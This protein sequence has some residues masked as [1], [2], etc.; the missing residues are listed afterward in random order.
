MADVRMRGFERRTSVADA[1]AL[2]RARV[3]ELP[4]ETAAVVAAAERVLAAE[5][6]SPV[7][8]PPFRRAMMDGWAVVAE[9]T[10]GASDYRPALLC[11][12]GEV[13]AGRG[14]FERPIASGEAL[15]ITTGAPLPDGA[16]AVVMAE[17]AVV[18]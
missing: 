16:D 8:L 2:L 17:I 13:R 9:S 7:D 5:V 1:L 12:V 18:R 10:L 3:A 11:A 4:A 14:S 6:R 15:R